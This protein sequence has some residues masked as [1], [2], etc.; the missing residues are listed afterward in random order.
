MDKSIVP[1]TWDKYTLE[2]QLFNNDVV[3][4]DPETQKIDILSRLENFLDQWEKSYQVNYF[5]NMEMLCYFVL[6]LLKNKPGKRQFIKF[7]LKEFGGRK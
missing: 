3:I 2:N 5:L 6:F 7:L 4:F 1:K